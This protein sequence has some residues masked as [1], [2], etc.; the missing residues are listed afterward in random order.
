MFE[1][2]HALLAVLAMWSDHD[3]ELLSS[4]LMLASCP[5]NQSIEAAKI[6]QLL[7]KLQKFC[8]SWGLHPQA[9]LELLIASYN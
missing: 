1:K 7:Q 2:V 9:P 5:Q 6:L 8:S 3:R 4:I